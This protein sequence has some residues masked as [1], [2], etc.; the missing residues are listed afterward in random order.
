MYSQHIHFISVIDIH[1]PTFRVNRVLP[2]AQLSPSST[3]AFANFHEVLKI[4][5]LVES[6]VLSR[7]QI[8]FETLRCSR[9]VY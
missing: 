1:S 8:F 5:H 2:Y 4:Q 7:F 9:L 6:T 3:S